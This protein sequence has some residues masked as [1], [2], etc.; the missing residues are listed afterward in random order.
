MLHRSAVGKV[1]QKKAIPVLFYISNIIQYSSDR[2]DSRSRAKMYS[3]DLI[4]KGNVTNE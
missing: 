4:V 1:S 3:G 2:Y